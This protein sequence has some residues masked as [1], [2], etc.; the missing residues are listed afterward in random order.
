MKEELVWCADAGKSRLPSEGASGTMV[1]AGAC[2]QQVAA[3]KDKH[4]NM[5]MM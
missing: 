4:V 1:R 5:E 2:K 3:F